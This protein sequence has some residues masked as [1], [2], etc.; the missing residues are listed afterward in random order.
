M[1]K[2][3]PNY[4]GEEAIKPDFTPD[5]IKRHLSDAQNQAIRALSSLENS[6]ADKSAS[7][8]SNT[9][10]LESQPNPPSL[11]SQSKKSHRFFGKKTKTRSPIIA[12]FISLLIGGGIFG[13][14]SFSFMTQGI[15]EN[16]NL[17]TNTQHLI[18]RKFSTKKIKK[19]AAGKTAMPAKT[20]RLLAKNNIKIGIIDDNGN[21]IEKAPV[22]GE[23]RVFSL[24]GD[25]ISAENFDNK[26]S[27]NIKF[28]EAIFKTVRGRSAGFYD[29]SATKTFKNKLGSSRDVFHDYTNTGDTEVDNASYKNLMD[30]HFNATADARINTAEDRTTTDENGNETTTRTTTGEDASTTSTP[31]ETKT[32]KAQNFVNSV[33][34]K[35][36]SGSGP[37][38]AVVEAGRIISQAIT[39]T[40]MY[41]SIK[42]AMFFSEASDKTKYGDGQHSAQNQVNNF[43]TTTTTT[44]VTDVD[45]GKVT[46]VT[47]AP[48]QASGLL[49]VYGSNITAASAK[50]FSL[51]RA[52]KSTVG[53]LLNS[54]ASVSACNAVR[55]GSAV[56]SLATTA[57]PVFGVP[58][59]IIGM[60]IETGIGVG[61]QLAVST[62]LAVLIPTIAESMFANLAS[63]ATGIAGGEL[64]SK[65]IVATNF[66]VAQ[67]ANAATPAS[68]ERTLGYTQLNNQLLAD[69]AKIDRLEKSP[70]DAS[71]PNTFLGTLLSK[72]STLSTATTSTSFNQPLTILTN[73]ASLASQSSRTIVGAAD[74]TSSYLSTFGDC[75]ETSESIGA[76]GDMYCLTIP[77]NDPSILDI[78][79]DDP[80]YL[81]V[82][83]PNLSYD[84]QG[85]EHII[86]GSRL[87][88]F[89]LY[90]MNRSSQFGILDANILSDCQ[91]SLG[92]IGDNLPVLSDI[93]DIVNSAESE[94]CKPWGDGSI[95]VNSADN[96]Y[97]DSEFK[98]YQR[99]VVSHRVDEMLGLHDD[100]N[101]NPVTGFT[102]SY[103]T[104]H[105]LD[106]SDAGYLA[107]I[108]GITKPQAEATIAYIRS[109]TDNTS[110]ATTTNQKHRPQ[111]TFSTD[112]STKTSDFPTGFST[113]ITDFSTASSI[114][115]I[116][117][118][119]FST[120]PSRREQE[121]LA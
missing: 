61:I 103:Y 84:E 40:E 44:E 120:T 96:P 65:G 76:V 17:H 25:I 22:K 113:N 42:F 83:S 111:V 93:V 48:T 104:T 66:Q 6:A 121:T 100:D 99:Y 47:G 63:D 49:K 101:P 62:A 75:P 51:E 41:N 1:V 74:G 81:A 90:V 13:L 72:F 32:A 31:G 2:K 69:E 86:E 67:T 53:S 97:W 39:A 5:T 36:A 60:L 35:V 18:I 87:A 94:E 91:S 68:A 88:K 92:I 70:F 112:F 85:N 33:S 107:R 71:S 7:T 95:A 119:D 27:Q 102:D 114:S 19:M 10:L 15:L 4:F 77:I 34:G 43:F 56:I 64:F 89:I 50:N 73:L 26:L 21:F 78:E 109:L 9:D 3:V 118:I 58:K 117:I 116:R 46:K 82:I 110:V 45:T 12:L 105:P 52:H 59:A 23:A 115:P 54:G 106:D 108:A 37:T 16:F 20:Q 79:D 30:E 57:I 28:R 29:I 80:N 38:C 14:S 98:Y 11:Y 8:N 24:D 55:A